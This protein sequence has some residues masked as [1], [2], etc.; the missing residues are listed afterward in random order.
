MHVVL[1]RCGAVMRVIVLAVS[2]TAT[3]PNVL[4]PSPFSHSPL[5][6]VSLSPRLPSL[7]QA[8]PPVPGVRILHGSRPGGATARRDICPHMARQSLPR[9]RGERSGFLRTGKKRIP[10]YYI[11]ESIFKS[12][13]RI[14]NYNI[15]V[16]VRTFLF[17][18]KVF[19]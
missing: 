5:L 3:Q 1:W 12:I 6:P 2:Y 15:C 10:C 7:T 19:C 9:R 4:T 11:F 16:V 17:S 14:L 13:S 18:V 8:S